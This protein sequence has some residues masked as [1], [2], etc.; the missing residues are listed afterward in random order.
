M[1][2]VDDLLTMITD[3]LFWFETRLKINGGCSQLS[4]CFH[5]VFLT[6]IKK[7]SFSKEPCFH[8][9]S[10]FHLHYVRNEQNLFENIKPNHLLFFLF[11]NQINSFSYQWQNL[12]GNSFI[13]FLFFF[14]SEKKRKYL[15]W[16]FFCFDQTWERKSSSLN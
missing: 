12:F 5:H 2:D 6:K 4:H 7:F 10:K 9:K 13:F 11:C 8:L 16:V 14:M 15:Q 1:I 3:I